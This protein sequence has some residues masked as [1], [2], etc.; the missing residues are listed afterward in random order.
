LHFVVESSVE[1]VRASIA[2]KII[3]KV[4]KISGPLLN[5]PTPVVE[6]FTIE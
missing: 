3:I 4:E 5:S 1:K 2:V 6:F